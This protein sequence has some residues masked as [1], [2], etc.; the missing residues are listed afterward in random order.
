MKF[1]ILAGLL[2]TAVALPIPLEQSGGSSSAQRFNFFPLQVSPFFPQIL[3]PQPPQLQIPILFPYNPNQVL[4]PNEFIMLIT[5]VL[6]QLGGF[7]GK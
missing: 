6:N 1:L 7:L 3:F 4:T 5:S 2:S